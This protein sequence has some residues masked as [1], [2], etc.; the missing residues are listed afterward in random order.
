[1]V[2]CGQRLG[3]GPA[4]Q[5]RVHQPAGGEPAD[6]D[7]LPAGLQT[8]TRWASGRTAAVPQVRRVRPAA[9]TTPTTSPNTMVSRADASS[10]SWPPTAL[11]TGPPSR[12]PSAVD[13]V[14]RAVRVA[15]TRLST[16]GG[17]VRWNRV[18]QMA[19]NG[20]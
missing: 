17:V 10:V 2:R 11:T 9:T 1:M 16:S 6:V 14:V 5:E 3:P 18:V 8:T 13:G 15:S 19:V 4:A 7:Q 12:V 20:P